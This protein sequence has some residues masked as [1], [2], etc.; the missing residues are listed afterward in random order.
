MISKPH[1]APY[2]DYFYIKIFVTLIM[3]PIRYSPTIDLPSL[4]EAIGQFNSA[5]LYGVL[6]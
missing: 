1:R 2:L 5:H 4:N 3:Y 6:S